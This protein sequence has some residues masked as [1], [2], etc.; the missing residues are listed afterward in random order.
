MKKISLLVSNICFGNCKGCYLDQRKGEQ[1]SLAEISKVAS[2]LKNSNYE[3]VTLSGGDPLT[4]NDIVE[5][6]DIFYSMDFNIHLDT[7]GTPL[8]NKNFRAKFLN[9]HTNKKISLVGI[10]FDGSSQ[11]IFEEFRTDWEGIKEETEEILNILNSNSFNISINTVVNKQNINDLSTIYK[12]ITKYPNVKRWELHQ[13]ISLSKK[14]KS[15]KKRLKISDN[16]FMKA[17]ESIN[18]YKNIEISPKTSNRKSNFKYID[19]NGDIVIVNKR[20]KN[21]I[22]NIRTLQ[23]QEVE[24]IFK[25]I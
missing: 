12:N 23:K 24:K 14:S 3:G 13:F 15:V 17:I 21:V 19:F 22:N 16:N 25:Q 1:L 5:I 10:P 18:N 7:T 8:L 4:R 20:K 6:I 11:E 9:N 2:F